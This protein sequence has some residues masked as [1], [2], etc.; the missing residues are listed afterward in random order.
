VARSSR[1]RRPP[2]A[3]AVAPRLASRLASRGPWLV[4]AALAAVFVFELVL[5]LRLAGHPLLQPVGELDTGEYWR[6]A[7]RVLGGDPWLTGT[8]FHVSPLYIYWLAFALAVGGGTVTG[9]LVVQAVG[10]TV[11]V[12]LAALTAARWTS[13]GAGAG[14]PDRR[15]AFVAAGVA[16]AAVAGTGVVALQ[17][18]LVLQSAIDPLLIALCAS[19]WTG[20]LLRGGAPRWAACGVAFALLA[21]NRP[22]AWLVAP[23][24]AGASLVT[25][26]VGSAP[27][28]AWRRA[29]AWALG[30][31]LV[32]GPFAVR[33]RV[34]TGEWQLLPGHGGL[35]LYIGNHDRATGTY[36]VVDGIRPS[37][38]GQR[39]DARRVA[40]AASGRALSDAEVS[41]W[42]VGRSVSWWRE[43]PL[44]ALRG[45]AYKVWLTTHAWE[46]PVN[47]SYGW[48]RE[49]VGLLRVLPIGAWLLLP[50][51]LAAVALGRGLVTGPRQPAWAW[52]RL[53]LPA[54]LLSVACFFVVDRYRAPALVLG[55]IHAGVLAGRAGALLSLR[56]VRLWAAAAV[57]LLTLIAG[58]VPLPFQL[59]HGDA[60]LGM[61]LHAIAQRRDGDAEAWLERATGRLPE[62]GVAWFRAGLAWQA[63]GD[64][65]QAER[66]LREAHRRDPEIAEVAFAL[67]G[68]L[69]SQGKGA[70]AAP[71]LASVERAGIHMDRV[72]LDLALALWQAGDRTGARRL[73]QAGVPAAGLPLLRARAFAAVEAR[74]AELAAW[75]L[76]VLRA[77]AAHDA[78]VAETLGLMR[79]QLGDEAAAA[80]L[81][82]EAAR[83]EPSRATARFNL[84][85]VRVRQGRRED[86]IALLRE[87]LRIDPTYAQAAGALREL[88]GRDVPPASATATADRPGR[89]R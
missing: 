84:A 20:A 50:L 34:A 27:Q 41:G 59:G 86:A 55:A 58:Q 72:R 56:G 61:A 38:E 35:N 33:S 39:D 18:A 10:G 68:V 52:F 30:V 81:F 3:P 43:A 54:Y 28:S 51:G 60:D 85:I 1:S 80:V 45:L 42:F 37:I 78:D 6:L 19:T 74:Q 26:G 62:A 87:A 16:G 64:L 9:A 53:L 15:S 5:A 69:L 75:L 83:L 13:A 70:E 77:H 57:A 82:A 7:Q 21:T 22:N 44:S 67:A 66:A 8:T 11:A 79:V 2:P 73:L 88:L 65:A 4:A 14:Q 32:L 24:L 31:A 40:E 36:T 12:G 49:Q 17:Q 47:V 23:L 48:F 89:P 29:T 71:L 76:D 63:R 46:L 25:P